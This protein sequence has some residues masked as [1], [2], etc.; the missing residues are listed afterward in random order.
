MSWCLDLCLLLPQLVRLWSSQGILVVSIGVTLYLCANGVSEE[1]GLL[2]VLAEVFSAQVG[3]GV[4]SETGS[5]P[6][7]GLR[8]LLLIIKSLEG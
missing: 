6:S 7:L 4:T 2:G 3:M 8:F 1:V 5:K